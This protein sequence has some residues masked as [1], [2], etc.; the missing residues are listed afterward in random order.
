MSGRRTDQCDG[1]PGR[2]SHLTHVESGR[3][4][5]TKAV[6]EREEIDEI[7]EEKPPT[8]PSPWPAW[9]LNK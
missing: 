1:Q 7:A 8:R 9:P 3:A 5:Y 6:V 4:G 2:A